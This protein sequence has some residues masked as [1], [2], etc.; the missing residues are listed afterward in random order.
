MYICVYIDI[1]T[2]QHH[3]ASGIVRG[4]V[5]HRTVVMMIVTMME[6]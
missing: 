6:I 1:Y 5:N 3:G 4:V 2:C